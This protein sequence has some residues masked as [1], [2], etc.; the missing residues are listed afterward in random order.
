MIDDGSS[1]MQ[2]RKRVHGKKQR[3]DESMQAIPLFRQEVI[4]ARASASLGQLRIRV[5]GLLS[6]ATAVSVLATIAIGGLLFVAEYTSVVAARGELVPAGGIV[7][8]LAPEPTVV[9]R[10]LRAEGQRVA[11]GELLFVLQVPAS[12]AA[13]PDLQAAIDREIATRIA[14]AG[15]EQEAAMSGIAAR[16]ATLKG[17]I[18]SL[19]SEEQLLREQNELLSERIAS[20]SEVVARLLLLDGPKYVSTLQ[21]EQHRG[22]LIDLKS[23]QKALLRSMVVLE[24]ERL[25]AEGALA[26]AR[27][28]EASVAARERKERA[29]LSQERLENGLRAG[30]RVVAPISGTLGASAAEPGQAMRAGEVLAMIVPEKAPLEAHLGVSSNEVGMLR[31]GL[32]VRITYDALQARASSSYGGVVARVSGVGSTSPGG[33]HAAAAAGGDRKFR[34]VVALDSQVARADG[35]PLRLVPGMTLDA[36]IQVRRRRAVDLIVDSFAPLRTAPGGPR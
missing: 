20:A 7:H 24:R 25:E 31:V 8:V 22:S 16:S 10:V 27:S 32:P 34:V 19:R 33:G 18:A 15:S 11:K 21:I 28:E 1:T 26:S 12:T 9:T 13:S 30:I 5:P 14:S 2:E 35:L 4:S 6:M 29:Q 17:R 36:A 3:E 23:Q